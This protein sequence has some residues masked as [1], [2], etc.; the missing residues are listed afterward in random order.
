M[1]LYLYYLVIICSLVLCISSFFRRISRAFRRVSRRIRRVG[2]R[3]SRIQRRVAKTDPKIFNSVKKSA[4]KHMKGELDKKEW[5]KLKTLK[6]RVKNKVKIDIEREVQDSPMNNMRRLIDKTVEATVDL[7]YLKELEARGED[8]RVY[9]GGLIGKV[10]TRVI[11]P[12]A[13]A[14][15][16]GLVTYTNPRLIPPGNI[17]VPELYRPPTGGPPPPIDPITVAQSTA[18]NAAVYGVG[19]LI[20]VSIIAVIRNR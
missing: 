20:L 12:L 5:I 18:I 19:A 7:A 15:G 6:K 17:I 14:G 1:N 9:D 2:R 4:F 10:L 3:V 13:T 11:I 16:I 8:L